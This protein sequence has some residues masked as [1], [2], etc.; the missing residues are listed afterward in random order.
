MQ[1]HETLDIRCADDD[2]AT[3]AAARSLIR[4]HL[5]THVA[6]PEPS[7]IERVLAALP[8]PYVAPKGGIWVAWAGD[9]PLGCMAL[10]ALSSDT[11][12]L[13][14][15]Y[16]KPDARG[17]GVARRLAEH[18]IR[19]ARARGYT[20]LR[21]GTQTTAIPAQRLYESLGFRRIDAYRASDFGNALFY[22]LS[23]GVSAADT[24]GSQSPNSY[25]M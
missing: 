16:V 3:F 4:V 19:E 2:P 14:R 22:E 15:V 5:V 23:L 11:G 1:I 24:I 8:S 13:K 9:D 25:Q 20:R 7:F 6:A 21:L 17:R 18:V 12:E 10:H